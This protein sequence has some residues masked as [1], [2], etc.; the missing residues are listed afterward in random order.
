MIAFCFCWFTLLYGLTFLL[1]KNKDIFSPIRFVAIKYA[2]LNLS[3]ILYLCFNPNSFYKKI[4]RVCNVT[5][6]QAFLQYT[7][8]QTIALISLVAG[9]LV[10][11]TKTQAIKP[12]LE[13]YNYKSTKILSIIFFIVGSIAYMIFLSRIGGLLYLL[14]NLSNRVALQ[15]GQHILNFLPLLVLS[16]LLLLLCIKIKN[17]L[18]DK[19]ILT[20]FFI[21]TLGVYS[22]FGS[23]ENSLIFIIVLIVAV[24]Y[25]VSKLEF[26]KKSLVRL[27][28]LT[29]GLFIYILVIPA[30]RNSDQ[31]KQ[32]TISQLF[33]IKKLVYNI[34]YTYIDV[35]AANYFNKESAWYLDG[36][37]DPVSALFAKSDKSNIPQVDQGV[38][39]N[40]IVIYQKDF[41]PPLPRGEVSK[42]SWPTENFGFAYSNF[43]IPGV[44]IFFFLQG[45]IFSIAYKLL[46]SDIYNPVYFLLYVLIIFTFN[47]SSLRIASFIKLVPLLYLASVI[48]NIC[49]RG[50]SFKSSLNINFK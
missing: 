18:S 36:Y 32:Y 37:F 35:F 4:L 48:F 27:S 47:F 28:V 42:T 45:N 12:V 33:N 21:I 17:K 30:I 13:Q 22:S 3:F 16:C 29:F 20:V 26:N 23:R 39:F 19:I 25:I 34:S 46:R 11:R 49:V 7:I 24:N 43:L 41:R 50:K 15:G 1:A 9:M 10:F 44:I 8:V 38:Y 5:L 2:I 6:E 31:G 14:R 40:S